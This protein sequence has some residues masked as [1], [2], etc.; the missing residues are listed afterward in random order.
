MRKFLYGASGDVLKEFHIDEDGSGV[1][2]LVQDAD[3]LLREVRRIRDT[4]DAVGHGENLRHVAE[5][6]L[7]VLQ[8]ATLERWDQADWRRWLND[9]DNQAFRTWTGRV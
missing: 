8:Q 2:N 4:G 6:P 1:F 5:I 7:T 9:R 3:P